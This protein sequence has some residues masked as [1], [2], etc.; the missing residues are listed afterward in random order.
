MPFDPDAYLKEGQTASGFDPDAYLGTEMGGSAPIGFVAKQMLNTTPMAHPIRNLPI[1]GGILGS[2]VANPGLGAAA[3]TGLGQILK[4]MA[5]IVSGDPSAPTTAMGAALPAMG[6]AALGGI[7]QEPKVLNAIPGV[8]QASKMAGDLASRAGKIVGN[9]AAR[10][11]EAASGVKGQDIKQLFNKPETL[12]NMGSRTAAGQAIGEAK[13]AAGVNPGITDAPISFTPEN[14]TKALQSDSAGEEAIHRVA[15]ANL[16][17]A[18]PEVED[19]G[20]G[21][22]YISKKIKD[23]LAKGENTSELQ[24]IQSH[25]NST[26]ERIAPDIQKARQEFAP[27]AQRDKFLKMFPTNKNG[28][29]SKANL[30]YLNSLLGVAGHTMAG[31]LGAAAGVTGGIIARAPI[32]T[33]LLTSAAGGAAKG[34][35]A[36]AE[37]PQARQILMQVLQRLKQNSPTQE[38]P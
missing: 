12:F 7:A 10:M 15:Q 30:F 27:I 26:L 21:L 23:G 37:N 31:R 29:I 22:K 4:N 5:G 35:N 13:L 14:I 11:G 8:P 20:D 16:S 9:F 19:I 3:G 6:Q 32:T 18:N 33:G 1:L 38:Q 28:T 25:L 2:T 17:G 36:I 24:N 34:L